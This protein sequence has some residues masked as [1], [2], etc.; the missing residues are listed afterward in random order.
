MPFTS[1]TITFGALKVNGTTG[2]IRVPIVAAV[3]IVR[4]HAINDS[5]VGALTNNNIKTYIL[6][7]PYKVMLRLTP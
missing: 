6:Y 3:R 5:L 4:A 7:T 1:D 2:T